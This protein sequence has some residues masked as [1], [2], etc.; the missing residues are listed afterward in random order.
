[1]KQLGLH[2]EKDGTVTIGQTPF[3]GFGVNL[4]PPF[5]RNLQEPDTKVFRRDFALMREYEIPFVRVPFSG[6]DCA[7]YRVYEEDPQKYFAAMDEIVAEAEKNHVGIIAS[8]MWMESAVACYVGEKRCRIGDTDSKTMAFSKQYVSDV[9]KRYV[10]RPGIWGW[11]IG[12]EYNLTADLCDP[13]IPDFLWPNIASMPH[14][15]IDGYDFYTS[16]ELHIFYRE[17]S[18]EIRKHDSYRMISSGNGDMRFM[19]WQLRA[20]SDQ[21]DEYHLWKN[22]TG[23]D[24]R[25]QFDEM[26]AFFTPD[27]MD[28]VCFHLQ[29]GTLNVNPPKYEMTLS[30]WGRTDV[31]AGEYFKAFAESAKR[32]H[33]GLFFG[34]FGDFIDMEQ[35]P[36]LE[37]N[38]VQI[39]AWIREAGIQL[40]AS[41]QFCWRDGWIYINDETPNDGMKLRHLREE[42]R[43][44]REEGKQQTE[45]AWEK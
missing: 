45:A 26:N 3:Y 41:W 25:E 11:E 18:A 38:F 5:I 14:G 17:I 35:D 9:V 40:A 30:R 8:L 43:R 13:T 1:M 22:G 29:H 12:N 7:L 31:S 33:K 36:E 4:F 44:Y 27:P 6:W 23:M 2:I 39:M 19:A 28:T 16:R 20:A 10:G 42:N 21:K 24:T 34:E 32:L 15:E 37:R